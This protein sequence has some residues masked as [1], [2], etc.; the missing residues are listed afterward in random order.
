MEIVKTV[1]ARAE[2]FRWGAQMTRT[3]K[4]KL[5]PGL[6]TVRIGGLTDSADTDSARLLCEEGLTF[7]DFRFERLSAVE[8]E[9]EQLEELRGRISELSRRSELLDLQEELWKKNGDFTARTALSAS[10]TE[11]YILEL[12]GRLAA[13]DG[14]RKQIKKDLAELKKQLKDLE[15]ER[16]LPVLTAKVNAPKEGEYALQL[17]YHENS[18]EWRPVYEISSDGEGPL[19]LSMK[20][21]LSQSTHEDWNGIRVSLFTGD[22]S[23]AGTLPEQRT[24]YLRL[25]AVY[26]ARMTSARAYGGMRKASANAMMMEDAAECVDYEES[27]PMM[28]EAKT[29]MAEVNSE[30]TMTE[31][32][33]PGLRDVMKRDEASAD[34]QDFSLNAEYRVSTVPADDPGAYLVAKVKTADLP[35]TGEFSPAVYLNGTYTGTVYLYPDYSKEETDITLGKEERIKVSRKELSRKASQNLFK[36]QRTEDREYEIRVNNISGNTVTVEVKDQVPVSADKEITLDVKELSGASMD[37]DTG[38]VCW[39]VELG[40]GESK[41]LNL[42]YSYTYPKDKRVSITY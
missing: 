16:E 13:L 19:L 29:A 20:A 27:A 3:G 1:P 4:V 33:L 34:L 32:A 11:Q 6:Q 9:S 28:A 21:R 40:A 2:I 7:Y 30:E 23:S 39:K 26:K 41:V 24:Q 37:K 22:P 38:F 12:P 8:E 25:G 5:V 18:A 42:K 15:R 31:Y 10:E 17:R 35:F 14:E 36:T